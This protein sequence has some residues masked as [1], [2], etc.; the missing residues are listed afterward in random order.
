M[1]VHHRTWGLLALL[2]VAMA[3]AFLSVPGKVL[4]EMLKQSGAPGQMLHV[5]REVSVGFGWWVV[6][7]PFCLLC[8]CV[9]QL[10]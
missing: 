9:P 2:D 8:G 1:G 3:K 6:I 7:N 4:P 5:I 10:S